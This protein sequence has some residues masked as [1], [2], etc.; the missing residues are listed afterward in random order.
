MTTAA[1]YLLN[2]KLNNLIGKIAALLFNAVAK[3][4]L[5]TWAG[6]ESTKGSAS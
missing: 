2:E 6:V 3:S 5:Y 4:Y 1:F